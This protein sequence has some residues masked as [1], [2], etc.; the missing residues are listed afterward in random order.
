MTW[1]IDRN[2]VAV[3]EARGSSISVTTSPVPGGHRC[4]R[5]RLQVEWI[6]LRIEGPMHCPA[7]SSKF[8]WMARRAATATETAVATPFGVSSGGWF[9]RLFPVLKLFFLSP[10]KG[11]VALA[12]CLRS[13]GSR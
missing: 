5:E 10:E 12:S 9:G 3:R 1:R 6:A 2:A 4:H 7:R 11:A 8:P 13:S